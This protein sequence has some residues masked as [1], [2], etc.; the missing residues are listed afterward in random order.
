MTA[1]NTSVLDKIHMLSITVKKKNM[2]HDLNKTNN[3][4]SYDVEK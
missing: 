4:Y 3:K 2:H 1:L